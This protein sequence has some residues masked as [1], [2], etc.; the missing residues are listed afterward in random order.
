MLLLVA[1]LAAPA[2]ILANHTINNGGTT[3]DGSTSVTV[4]PGATISLT[5]SVTLS[6]NDDWESTAWRIATSSF[7]TY[8]CVNTTDHSNPNGTV[9]ETFDITAPAGTGHVQP[10]PRYVG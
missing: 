3:L 5:V 10:V 1:A 4:A 6:N 8:T 7:G 2:A 9:T